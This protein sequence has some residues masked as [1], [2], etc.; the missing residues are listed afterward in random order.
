MRTWK[1]DQDIHNTILDLYKDFEKK[2]DFNN[3]L[4]F[5]PFIFK[6]DTKTEKGLIKLLRKGL[7][8]IKNKINLSLHRIKTYFMFI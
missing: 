4:T 2:S 8:H 7:S 3:V 5:E 1:E 6:I